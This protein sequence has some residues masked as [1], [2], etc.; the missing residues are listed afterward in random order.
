MKKIIF[1]YQ[2]TYEEE[3]NN[4]SFLQLVVFDP[5]NIDFKIER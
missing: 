2:F 4:V 1:N 3:Y 5:S